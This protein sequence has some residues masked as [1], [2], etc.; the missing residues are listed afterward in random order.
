MN[1]LLTTVL[2]HPLFV[3]ESFRLHQNYPNPFNPSTTIAFDMPTAGVAK[4]AV[5]NIIGQEIATLFDASVQPGRR[6]AVWNGMDRNGKMAGSGIYLIRFTAS[7]QAGGRVHAETRK[8][9]LVR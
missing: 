6:L 7:D 5:F 3:P 4:L 9:M 1:Q 8:M 2:E